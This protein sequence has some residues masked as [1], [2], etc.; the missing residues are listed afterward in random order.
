MPEQ[1]DCGEGGR[2][3]DN[4]VHFG[5]V[6]RAAGL[7]VG[8]GCILQAQEAVRRV[9]L[10]ERG[11]FYWT[12]HAVFVSRAADRPLFEQAFHVFWRN[13]RF[14]EKLRG[15]SL[16]ATLDA[17]L[18]QPEPLARRVADAV[19]EHSPGHRGERASEHEEHELDAVLTWSDKET[20]S[21]RDFESM[22]AD[23]MA[24]AKALIARFR[25]LRTDYPTR[26]LR[27]HRQG[28]TVHLRSSVRQSLRTAPDIIHLQMAERR[29]RPAP[30][31]ILCDVSGSMSRY[32][33]ML[34]HFAHTVSSDH[35]RVFTFVFG[36]RLT[37]ITRMLRHRDVD[38]ALA[39]V[40][41][42]VGDWDGGTRIG[43]CLR[44]FNQDWSRRVLAQGAVVLF[45]TDGLDR[46]AGEGLAAQME[47]LH[48]SCRR[49]ICLNPLL[50]Y[51]RYE[52]K[53]RGMQAILPHVD[54]FRTIHNLDSMA[55]L[56]SALEDG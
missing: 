16:P 4:L 17:F 31:V 51:D 8:P 20:F 34:M 36:T 10:R 46:D 38:V 25:L 9:G 42:K 18:E 53:T 11:D 50:R 45:I 14:L 52:P 41:A 6:L 47:R 23:E 28:R 22:S 26:R 3:L 49:L 43:Q 30:L 54:E 2:L 24:R 7:R 1:L 35:D 40:G 13:P 5:R 27:P 48:K 33:R 32:A 21:A 29:R 39:E 37:H 15:L 55:A 19:A 12:L 44:T 56:L